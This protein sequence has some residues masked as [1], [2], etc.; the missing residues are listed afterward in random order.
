MTRLL[1]LFTFLLFSFAGISQKYKPAEAGSKVHFTIKNFG[2]STGGDLSGLK[3][4]IN[5][6]AANVTS[7]VFN[8]SVSVNTIDTDSDTRDEH[9]KSK[10]YFDAAKYPEITI[11]STKIS[12]TNKTKT[13]VYYF[14]GNL[15][16]LGVTKPIAFPFTAI[17]KLNDYL[18]TGTFEINRL[19]FGVGTSSAVLSN[20]VKVSLSILAKKS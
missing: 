15:T 1:L 10:E 7:S 12:T 4:D 19:D 16:L 6:V 2:I 17:K 13:G 20:T 11:V 9:L 8:I 18:F 5:F 14:T 3:G